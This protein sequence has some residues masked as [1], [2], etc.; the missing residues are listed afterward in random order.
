MKTKNAF[1]LAEVIIALFILATSIY[2]L[3]NLQFRALN[4]A[5][6]TKDEIIRVFFIK[7]YIYQLYSNPPK[8]EKPLKVEMENPEVVITAHKQEIDHKKSSLKEFSKDIDIIW[9]TGS[10]KQAG[11]INKELK[12]ISFVHKRQEKKNK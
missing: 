4:K 9:S 12:M 8:E 6:S 7:K 2:I 3:S 11:I 5:R 10:W 1:T